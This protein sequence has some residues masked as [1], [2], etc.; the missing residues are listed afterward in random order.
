MIDVTKLENFVNTELTSS[1]KEVLVTKDASGKYYL[2]NKYI[3]IQNKNNYNVYSSNPTLKLEFTSL[4]N[5]TA[6][7]IF[8]NAGKYK[9]ARRVETLDLRLS[10]IDV[11]IAVHKNK[12]KTS[13]NNYI[14]LISLTKLQQDTYKRR[15][16]VSELTN[17][18]DNSKRIQD[19]NFATKGSKIKYR[20]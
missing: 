6:W 16:I 9:D 8:D 4:K 10:S 13:K 17:Y 3:I 7:C 1:L 15:I 19:S 20:R 12:I 14:T 11:D 2:F 5:A 18:I